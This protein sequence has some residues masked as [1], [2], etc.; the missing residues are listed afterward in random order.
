[1]VVIGDTPHDISCGKVIGART[2]AVATGP[3]YELE[4]LRACDPWLAWPELPPP[5]ELLAAL[6][7]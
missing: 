2:I 6:A 1:M 7:S 4:A 5:D 3:A